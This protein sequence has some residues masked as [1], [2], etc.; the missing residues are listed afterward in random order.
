MTTISDPKRVDRYL[1]QFQILEHFSCKPAFT[2]RRYLPGELL[3]SP[4]QETTALQFIVEGDVILYDMPTE[5]SVAGVDSPFYRASLIGEAEL[6]HSGFQT[7]FVEA[8]TEVYTL[9][10]PF[11]EY[12]ERLLEDNT[13]LRYVC[14][15]LSEKLGDATATARRLPLREQLMRYITAAGAGGELRDLAHLSHLLHVSTRQLARTLKALCEEGIL[16]RSKKGVY[17]IIKTNS[18]E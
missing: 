10:L 8:K 4:F 3:A 12:R 5:D 1:E 7:F 15:M 13:F 17:R 16:E 18:M 14:R 11:S 9:A 6:I 2:L